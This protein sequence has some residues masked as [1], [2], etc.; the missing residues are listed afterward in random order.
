MLE[1]KIEYT[2]KNFLDQIKGEDI[3]VISHFDTDGITSGTI[4]LQTLKRLDQKF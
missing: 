2:V 3:L 4:I 1:V